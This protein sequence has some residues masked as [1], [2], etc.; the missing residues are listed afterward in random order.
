MSYFGTIFSIV[1][2]ISLILFDIQF[3]KYV[4][5]FITVRF[6]TLFLDFVNRVLLTATNVYVSLSFSE[7]AIFKSF[8]RR[9]SKRFLK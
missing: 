2:F 9:I 6:D 3:N 1:T 7:C 8:K 5:W 4:Y